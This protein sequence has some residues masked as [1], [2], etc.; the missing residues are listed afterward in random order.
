MASRRKIKDDVLSE[1]LNPT[2]FFQAFG[3]GAK[4]TIVYITTQKGSQQQNEKKFINSSEHPL[5]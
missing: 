3:R 2:R 1:L 5:N 4:Y